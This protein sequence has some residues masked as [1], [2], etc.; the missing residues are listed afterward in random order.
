MNTEAEFSADHRFAHIFFSLR[1]C[2]SVRD[3]FPLA[4]PLECIRVD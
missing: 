4:C 2:A 1:L 3:I